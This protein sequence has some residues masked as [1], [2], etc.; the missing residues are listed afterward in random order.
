MDYGMDVLPDLF[1]FVPAQTQCEE[2]GRVVLLTNAT[3]CQYVVAGKV[4]GEE[5]YCGVICAE[6]SWQ[7]NHGGMK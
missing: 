6:N 4:M 3:K 1:G 5:H 2:C 7:R